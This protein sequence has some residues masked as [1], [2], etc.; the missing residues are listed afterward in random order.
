M[1]NLRLLRTEKNITP[2]KMADD[3]GISTATVSHYELGKREPDILTLIKL[4]DYFDCTVDFLIGRSEVRKPPFRERDMKMLENLNR[5]TP[6]DYNLA[7]DL[8]LTLARK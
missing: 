4:A 5:L 7:Y 3:L 2:A 1:Q 6:H 8:I